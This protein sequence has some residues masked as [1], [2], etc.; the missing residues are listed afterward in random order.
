MTIYYGGSDMLYPVV[1]TVRVQCGGVY[2]DQENLA[3]GNHLRRF[4]QVSTK[5][6]Q[7]SRNIG[8]ARFQR[9]DPHRK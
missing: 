4:K 9:I 2:H 1:P 5:F 6:R 3:D 7:I 8:P